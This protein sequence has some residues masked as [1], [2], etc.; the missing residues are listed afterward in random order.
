[1][2]KAMYHGRL[3]GEWGGGRPHRNVVFPRFAGFCKFLR[4]RGGGGTEYKKV[5]K[6]VQPATFEMTYSVRSIAATASILRLRLQS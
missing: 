3:E 1:M 4:R 5:R 2:Q 6:S